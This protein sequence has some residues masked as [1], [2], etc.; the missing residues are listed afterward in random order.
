[1][2]NLKDIY[3]KVNL[4]LSESDFLN[5]SIEDKKIT[6][7]NAICEYISEKIKQLKPDFENENMDIYMLIE[8]ISNIIPKNEHLDTISHFTHLILQVASTIQGWEIV[9]MIENI[10][11]PIVQFDINNKWDKL[12]TKDSEDLV[13]IFKFVYDIFQNH[14]I[15]NKL[16]HEKI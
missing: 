10:E 6:L 5:Q 7:E 9:W 12:I 3:Y 4:I 16:L 1:M 15:E 2:I 11:K 13:N 8:M 14:F